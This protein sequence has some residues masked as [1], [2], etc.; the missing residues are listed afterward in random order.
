VGGGSLNFKGSVQRR[1]LFAGLVFSLLLANPLVSWGQTSEINTGEDALFSQTIAGIRTAYSTFLAAHSTYPNDPVINAYLALTRLLDRALNEEAS[2]V[3]GLLGE[4]GIQRS[5]T[6]LESLEFQPTMVGDDYLIVPETAPSAET[7][8]SFGATTLLNDLTASIA[9]LDNT[10][11]H[12]G[13]SSK[14]IV[15]KTKTGN[16][17]D[18]EWD[19]GDIYLFRA[20]L[21]AA[22][23]LL[24]V[25]TA[26]D[27][28]VDVREVI[29]LGNID[30]LDIS[31]LL[32]R[33]P[34]LLKLLT[35][36]STPSVNGAAQLALARTTLMSAIDDYLLASEKVRNDPGTNAGAEELIAIEP[37]DLL[38]EELLRERLTGL[39]TSLVNGTV[40]QFTEREEN[41]I[42]TGG[43]G[44]RL[45]VKLIDNRSDGQFWGLDGVDFVSGGGGIECGVIE[46]SEMTLHMVSSGYFWADVTFVGTLNAQRT[47]ITSGSYSGS[48]WDGNVSGTFTGVQTGVDEEITR[49]NLN[50]VFGN[51]IAPYKGP[52]DA[53]ALLPQFDCDNEPIYETMGHGLGDDATLGGILPDFTQDDWG[54]KG[55]PD[56]GEITIPSRTIN[57]Q[58]ASVTDWDGI[59]PVFTDRI[60]DGD[61]AHSGS[62]LQH[63]YLAKDSQFLYVR[64]TLADGPPSTNFTLNPWQTLG[65]FVQFRTKPEEFSGNRVAQADYPGD[66][67]WRVQVFERDSN[68]VLVFQHT[69]QGY[70]QPVG[71]NLEWKVP[72]ADM[73]SITGKTLA[74]WIKWIPYG[75][76]YD[77]NLTCLRIGPLTSITVNLTVP[78][79]DGTGLVIIAVFRDDGGYNTLEEN[80]VGDLMFLYPGEY[81][82]T[83]GGM[84]LPIDN[85]P[86]GE[87]VWVTVRWDADFTGIRTRGDYSRSVGPVTIAADGST[88]VDLNANSMYAG[89]QASPYFRNCNVLAFRTQD[90]TRTAFQAEVYDPNGTVPGTIS[91]VR[92]IYPDGTTTYNFDLENEYSGSNM[93]YHQ[94]EFDQLPPIGEYTFTVTDTEGRT[95]T[96]HFYFGGGPDLP[97]VDFTTLQ[98]SGDLSAATL[99]WGAVAG[100]EGNVFY[101]ARIFSPLPADS[102]FW[103]SSF[104]TGTSVSIPGD[105]LQ[106]V[107]QTG[108]RWRVEAFDNHSYSTSYHRS[109]TNKKSLLPPDNSTPYFNIAFVYA[110]EAAGETFTCLAGQVT[111]PNGEAP[112]TIQS[113]TVTGPN[114]LNE[115]ILPEHW[116][117]GNRFVKSVSGVPAEGFYTFMITDNEG[118]S[119][120]SH[121]YIKPVAVPAVDVNTLQASGDP[122]TPTLSWAAPA[123]MTRP[124]Y[125]RATI[126][127]MQGTRVFESGR[128]S[129]TSVNVPQGIL[130]E[131]VAYRWDVR[132]ADGSQWGHLNTESKSAYANLVADNQN[133]Y[134]NWTEVHRRHDT[135]GSFTGLSASVID[136][137]GSLPGSLTSLT[138]ET[139]PPL[140]NTHVLVNNGNLS[141]GV[142]YDPS[143]GEIFYRAPG[144]F[145]PGEYTF[146]LVKGGFRLVSH[147]WVG[148]TPEMPLV[149]QTT[150]TVS[151]NPAA[152]TVSW[153]GVSGFEGNVYYRL[154]VQDTMGS[155]AYW[156]SR[157]PLTAQTIPMG[158]LEPGKIYVARV[159]AQEHPDW[160]T[161]NSRSNTAYVWW[162]SEGGTVTGLSGRVTDEDGDP[163]A[164]LHVYA[165]AGSCQGPW[166][167]GT[168]TDQ[169]GDYTLYLP[170]GPV[171]IRAC[172]TCLS[173][174]YVDEWYN[175]VYNC[176]DATPV[177]IESGQIVSGIDFSLD[178]GGTVTGY[179]YEEG[180]TTAI[181][182]LHVF[183]TDYT[184]GQWVAGT[185]TGQDGSYSLTLPTGT[186]RVKACPSCMGIPY[187]DEWFDDASMYESA[188]PV[189]VT[190]PDNTPG[191]DFILGFQPVP[192]D[193]NGDRVLTLADAVVG[194]Q[195]V[196]GMSP[197]PVNNS[198]HVNLDGKLGLAEVIFV[199]QN[200]AGLR[201]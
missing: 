144:T 84:N 56:S 141:N 130:G 18:L 23:S 44:K 16:D 165:H 20:A 150:I 46:G 90:G 193:I 164:N 81:T 17:Q 93:Y 173:L 186:Y 88:V 152:P 59:A 26:Y 156:G 159:E 119:A 195:L 100:Y 105:I 168:N 148:N 50:P 181:A 188:D 95:A 40:F 192:G 174:P 99:S 55:S 1:C 113:I 72:L 10:V 57:V 29:A 132:G 2:G 196:A 171:V 183:A 62:D 178:A 13:D 103:T 49:I 194:L 151:G 176:N 6:D 125:Y 65:Y 43:T 85:L 111:D 9:N 147:D 32:D 14:H 97:Y 187:I 48:N 175:D 28:D 170:T 191:I 83:P 146:T 102:T 142:S 47:Q 122:L 82:P 185:N 129:T 4:Y 11:S 134:F 21:K 98:A 19:Y 52:Y 67:T 172:A 104:T 201:P 123:G 8:R 200:V 51:G 24:L 79:Y 149:D 109:V 94:S 37:C 30:A 34:D 139:P 76:D 135:D 169:N 108:Y 116:F 179:V 145:Q 155:V 15:S 25:A 63:L 121:D 197:S 107:A 167:A 54:L 96:T 80:R 162:S 120:T 61:P 12:W 118:K 101:R 160:V 36:A 138:V 189:S 5:G 115:P 143:S 68:G 74:A 117:G 53:R 140:G 3:T 39:K 127:N 38:E 35:T 133:P 22:K 89:D 33:Y 124:I 157:D 69:Y 106:Q 112:T 114:N 66:G 73:G 184:T 86:A 60:D 64:M 92:V 136:P 78:D 154:R 31:K 137:S 161:Y 45:Q 27:I 71:N 42:F 199:L 163:I 158:S 128:T 7:L 198:A 77:Q 153:S 166:L 58:D 177:F 190:A 87:T 131:G 182:N 70:A 110:Y 41:W 91:E 180:G 75:G 126:E